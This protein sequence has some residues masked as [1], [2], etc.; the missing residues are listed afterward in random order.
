MKLRQPSQQKIYLMR[1][2]KT[3]NS[4]CEMFL[5]CS[6]IEFPK[7]FSTSISQAPI[8]GFDMRGDAYSKN[9]FTNLNSLWTLGGLVNGVA[10]TNQQRK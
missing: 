8:L 2:Q 3:E 5:L 1:K 9:R 7:L 4:W 6:C 10:G